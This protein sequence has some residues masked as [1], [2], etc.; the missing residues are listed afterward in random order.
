MIF[1]FYLE[2]RAHKSKPK[3]IVI[4]VLRH[5]SAVYHKIGVRRDSEELSRVSSSVVRLVEDKKG[6]S[7]ETAAHVGHV[8]LI[9]A[10]FAQV[11]PTRVIA[12]RVDVVGVAFLWYVHGWK[13]RGNAIS[14]VNGH[15]RIG[16]KEVLAEHNCF[17]VVVVTH[18]Y[19]CLYSLKIVL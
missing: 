14:V 8:L 5:L 19:M 12:T 6:P 4:F 1:S 17:E 3:F 18:V 9:P 13:R 15:V 10:A 16:R 2:T 11:G 7:F